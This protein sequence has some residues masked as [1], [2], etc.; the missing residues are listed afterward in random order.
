MPTLA[1]L[2]EGNARNQVPLRGNPKLVSE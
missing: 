1:D 2:A